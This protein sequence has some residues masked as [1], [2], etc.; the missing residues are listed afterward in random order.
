MAGPARI[1]A[2]DIGGTGLKAALVDGRGQFL[3]ERLRVKT[4]KPCPPKKLLALL[5]KLAAPL[6]RYDAITIGFPGYV[7][8]GLVCTAP[9]LG[10]KFWKDY[11]LEAA[12]SRALGKPARLLN[13]ADVQGLAAIRG[14]G[15]ELVVT[16]GT[17]FGTAWFHDGALLPHLEFA[18]VP[19]HHSHDFDRWIGERTRRKIGHKKWAKRVQKT[20]EILQTVFNYDHL[21]IGGGNANR[22]D[23]DL[24]GHASLIPNEDGMAGAAFAWVRRAAKPA[25]HRGPRGK[26]K[27]ASGA[28]VP[29][30]AKAAGMKRGKRKLSPS[31]KRQ[32]P[33][34]Q[35]RR[36]GSSRQRA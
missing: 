1:L 29:R 25:E 13:D 27:S 31:A 11:P 8:R 32:R 36:S 7:K 30:G 17:G 6:K 2:F 9:N 4:P 33:S 28:F 23:F 21:F 15:L 22:I 5:V 10:S 20:F 18:H 19:V 3:S 34:R 24:P 12:L 16:L 26:G 35:S 14:R